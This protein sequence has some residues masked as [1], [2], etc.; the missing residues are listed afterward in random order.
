MKI[1]AKQ[2]KAIRKE[3]LELFADN[4]TWSQTDDDYIYAVKVE[5]ER[6][7]LFIFAPSG[8]RYK[9]SREFSNEGWDV[10]GWNKE[11]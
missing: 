6:M 3:G 10:S 7:T 2:L 5:D 11:E 4:P 8:N 1:N 9:E